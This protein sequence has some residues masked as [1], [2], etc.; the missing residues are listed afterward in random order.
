[1]VENARDFFETLE[2]RVP[3]EK[4]EGMDATYRFDLEGS[5]SWHVTVR[6]GKLT[7]KEST[8]PA[9]CIVRSSEKT[10]AKVLRG[11]QKPAVALMLGKIKVEGDM[12]L[13]LKLQ[14][15]L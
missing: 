6:D 7:V 4:I 13:A 10:L 15:I 11:E 8:D 1:M 14:N 2:G 12:G 5:G 3:P 9:D